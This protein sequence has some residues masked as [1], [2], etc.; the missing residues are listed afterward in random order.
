MMERVLFPGNPVLIVDDEENF[1]KSAEFL[2][3]YE[4]INN[5]VTCQDSRQVLPLLERQHFSLVLLDL[6]MPHVSGQEL[7]PRIVED[8]PD[9]PVV[10]ITAENRIESAVACIKAGAYDYMVKPVG[11]NKLLV[12]VTNLIGLDELRR[13]NRRLKES[14]IADKLDHP[15]AFQEI[16]SRD[17]RMKSIFQYVEA[18]APTPLPVLL[19][20]ETGTGKELLARVIHDLSGRKGKFVGFNIAGEDA[21]LV[22]D[23]LFGHSKGGFTGAVAPRKGLIEQADCGTLFVD[24]IGDLGTDIQVKLLRVLQE[25]KFYPIGSDVE[26]QADT[27]FIFATNQDI[28]RLV[29]EKKFRKDLYYRLGSHL[30]HLPPLRHRRADIPLLIEHLVE[31]SAR[32]LGKK[33]PTLPGELFTLLEN[34]HF[35]GNVRE[36][37]GMISDAL[38]RHQKGILSMQTFLAKITPQEGNREIADTEDPGSILHFQGRFPKLKEMEKFLI[39]KALENAKGNQTIAARLLGISRKALNNRLIRN[40]N[41]RCR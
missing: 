18:I 19:I 6:M 8:Y 24:E 31:K 20:G 3:K 32:M 25:R 37:E 28:E 30:I 36:L 41:D 38:S 12:T 11:E 33:V 15:E 23:T 4:G 16:I 14:F 22:S 5:L 2:L 27:R 21:S 9:L 7:L 10:V 13:E 35:P 39:D 1:L 26:K 40:K 17:S 29:A 34:Y